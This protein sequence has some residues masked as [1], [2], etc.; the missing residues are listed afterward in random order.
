MT[1]SRKSVPVSARILLVDDNQHGNIARKAF[2]ETLGF[3][4]DVALSGEQAWELCQVAPF[5]VIVTDLRMDGMD[6]IALINLVRASGYPAWTV[7][8]SGFAGCLGLTEESTGADAV[9]CKGAVELEHLQRAILQLLARRTRRKS[10]N[11]EKA[12]VT[13]APAHVT[14][15]G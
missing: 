4:V 15:S 1:R 3:T 14:R 8:L 7:L 11:N 5:D 6:G 2:L 12:P 10:V 9:V 13:P